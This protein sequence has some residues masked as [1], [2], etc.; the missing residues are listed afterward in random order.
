MHDFIV[1]V[2]R[3]V[4]AV[5]VLNDEKL[6]FDLT[7]VGLLMT[8]ELVEH[9]GVGDEKVVNAVRDL[10]FVDSLELTLKGSEHGICFDF[11]SVPQAARAGADRSACGRSD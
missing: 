9:V 5:A 3:N 8:L 4:H 6:F 2:E 1:D 11:V 10:H 7:P